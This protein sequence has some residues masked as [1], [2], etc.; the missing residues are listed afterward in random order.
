M[1]ERKYNFHGSINPFYV[2]ERQQ[3]YLKDLAMEQMQINNQLMSDL[4]DIFNEYCEPIN[5]SDLRD[6]LK[7]Y[8]ESTEMVKV[9]PIADELEAKFN[10]LKSHSGN[11]EDERIAKLILGIQN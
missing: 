2:D 3:E 9:N 7:E 4:E 10:F 8:D 1:A 5:I 6:I 11:K